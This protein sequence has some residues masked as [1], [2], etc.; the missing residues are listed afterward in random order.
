MA[1][2]TKL[3]DDL[4]RLDEMANE[5]TRMANAEVLKIAHSIDKKFQGFEAQ[6]KDVDKKVEM[7]NSKVQMVIEQTAYN[8]DDQKGSSLVP[9]L[10]TVEYPTRLQGGNCESALNNLLVNS[11]RWRRARHHPAVR[12]SGPGLSCRLCG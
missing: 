1:G 11:P 12:A 6:V 9:S 7:V 3:E 10:P 2:I 5:E 4:K 8:L